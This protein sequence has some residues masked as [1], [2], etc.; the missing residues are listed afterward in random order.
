LKDDSSL[1]GQEIEGKMGGT[2]T[3]GKLFCW[4]LIGSLYW[5]Y[6]GVSNKFLDCSAEIGIFSVN[7]RRDF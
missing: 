2:K 3:V 1:G 4:T 7:S 5:L 6:L